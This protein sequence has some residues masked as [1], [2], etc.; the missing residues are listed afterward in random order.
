MSE[1]WGSSSGCSLAL[2]PASG[3]RRCKARW[4]TIGGAPSPTPRSMSA[5]R[6]RASWLTRQ[7]ASSRTSSGATIRAS[8]PPW[9]MRR[10]WCPSPLRATPRRIACASSCER[11]LMHSVKSSSAP[12]P[13]TPPMPSCAAPSPTR[14]NT[15]TWCVA[16]RPTSTSRGPS[17]PASCPVSDP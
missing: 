17:R 4:W 9:V 15:A 11:W 13:K 12:A 5:R 8:S 1:R 2:R 6:L 10:S 7:A 14:R 16:T 3:R